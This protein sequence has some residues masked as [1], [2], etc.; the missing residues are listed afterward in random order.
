MLAEDFSIPSQK[1]KSH[2]SVFL[3]LSEIDM[4]KK[5]LSRLVALVACAFLLGS[6]S[7]C[8]TSSPLLTADGTYPEYF[9]GTG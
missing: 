8:N 4:M 7:G 5:F 2:H 9:G 3:L 6:I 1:K